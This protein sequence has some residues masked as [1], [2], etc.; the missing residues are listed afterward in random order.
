M[1]PH[2]PPSRAPI[3]HPATHLA[4]CTLLAAGSLSAQAG[5]FSITPVRLYMGPKDRALAVTVTN[6]GDA[7]MVLQA[8]SF[9]WAQSADGQDQ[10][11]PTSDLVLAPP[12]VKIPPRG[13]QVVR[14]ALLA[15]RDASRQLTYRIIVREVP[16][17][18]PAPAS[19]VQ[20]QVALAMNLPVFVTP[21]AAK[22]KLTCTL[23]RKESGLQAKCTNEGAAYAQ[24]R[25]LRVQRNQQPLAKFEGGTYILPGASRVLDLKAEQPVPPGAVTLSTRFDDST[26]ATAELA[27]P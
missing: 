12:I 4:L 16:E 26:E 10:L 19:G 27:L 22:H 15:P 13:R 14:L 18:A 2:P 21:A 6:G 9:E 11:T 8:E 1:H 23:L 3:R 20:V 25:E 24:V 7:E 17:A 5:V